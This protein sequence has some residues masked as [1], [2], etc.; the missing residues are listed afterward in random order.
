MT[1][2][3][4]K[5]TR[6]ELRAQI[7]C[8]LKQ[9]WYIDSDREIAERLETTHKT[10][11]KYRKGLEERGEILPRLKS[12]HDVAPRLVEV[13]TSAIR[14][15]AWND[16]VYDPVDSKDQDFQGFCVSIR[17]DGIRDP[18]A[19]TADGVIVSGHRRHA[20]ARY[21]KLR[22][23]TV[24]VHPNLTSSDPHFCKLLVTSNMQR[25]KNIAE[26]MREQV[27]L[28]SSDPY[29]RV[30]EFREQI[31]EMAGV[32][33]VDLGPRKKRPS[34]KYKRT[35]ATTITNFVMSNKKEW[36][37]SARRVFY[38]ML[39]V[40]GLIRNDR[41]KTPFRNDMACYKDV[42][43]L[44]GRLRIDKTIPR[45]AVTDETRPVIEWNTHRS[46]SPFIRKELRKLF[47]NYWR[48]LQQSQPNH[49]ELLIEK[50]TVASVVKGIAG[51]YRIPMTSGRGY[52]S[53]PPREDMVERYQ[54][55]GKEKLII[56]CVSD[57]DPEGEDI[58]AAFGR[59]IRDD[60]NIPCDKLA[61]VKS[62]LTSKQV[63]TL[64]LHAGQFAKKEGSRYKKFIKKYGEKHGNRC[65]ELES[66]SPD[67]LRELL[68]STI[69]SIID[70]ELFNAEVEKEVEEQR[71]LD[72]QK[73]D[74]L[75]KLQEIDIREL[76]EE[77][78]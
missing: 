11:W 38:A 31:S 5:R 74:I 4:A 39:N 24:L 27:A 16:D 36:P 22:K 30:H 53:L 25:S 1:T 61:V 45:G 57:F 68:E 23:I 42:T 6:K 55:S 26:R 19:V 66:L 32:E 65:W 52:S 17:D 48:D 10:V 67:T 12:T 51:N 33:T 62:G 15:S 9:H 54:K 37:F 78:L 18:I 75:E 46:V 21:L 72:I 2:T 35:L 73:R 7:E 41:T 59:S 29:Q 56:I 50:N 47:S 77:Q 70:I 63:E 13:C 60:F 71:K 64:H 40:E 8:E 28:D 43:D 69:R 44:L 3:T 58:P 20:A 34:I 49:I 14:P 76:D